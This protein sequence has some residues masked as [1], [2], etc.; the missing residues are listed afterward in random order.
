VTVQHI[1]SAVD[2]TPAAVYYHFASK[3][4]ILVEGV[5]QFRDQ[6]LAELR[7]RLPEP[8][9]ADGIRI[10]LAEAITWAARH[11][12]PATVYFVRSIGRNLVVEAVRRRTRVELVEILRDAVARARGRLG[13]AEAGVTAVALVSLLETALASMLNRDPTYRGLGSRRFTEEVC[14]LGERIAGIERAPSPRAI[15]APTRH[16]VGDGAGRRGSPRSR[17]PASGGA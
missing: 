11:R 8:G 13:P 3:D 14:A 5:Q 16:R 1:A 7:H 9:D 4:Q 12:A 15:T 10:L 17:S 2:V 6:L